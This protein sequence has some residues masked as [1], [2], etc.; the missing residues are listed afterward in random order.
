M[1][2][3]IAS[4][5][6]Y[7]RQLHVWKEEKEGY[8]RFYVTPLCELINSSIHCI[9]NKY[10]DDERYIYRFSVRLWDKQV[11]LNMD[12][13]ITKRIHAHNGW[14][15]NQNQPSTLNF[16]LFIKD[17]WLCQRLVKDSIKD[18]GEFLANFKLELEFTIISGQ[19]ES[20]NLN[21]T[22]SMLR[23][24]NFF[25]YL[26]NEV[27]AYGNIYL[28]STDC[29]KLAKNIYQQVA[30]DDVMTSGYIPSEQ[31]NHIIQ[32]LLGIIS[33]Q[34]VE[35]TRLSELE[36]NSVFWDDIFTRP[37]I[38]TEY[39]NEV[40]TYNQSCNCFNFH[41]N[42]EREFYDKIS[43]QYAN[44]IS[45]S[46]GDGDTFGIGSFPLGTTKSND[47]IDETAKHFIKPKIE[48]LDY[49]VKLSECKRLWEGGEAITRWIDKWRE[50]GC[51]KH[52][53]YF[54]SY[55]TEKCE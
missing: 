41:S 53:A 12:K 54:T 46:S 28:T 13:W 25:T 3:V 16:E 40:F 23:K 20:H 43:Y 26:S 8:N 47:R 35:S 22:G 50:M 38:Q 48:W 31:E 39:L 29:N 37:D 44:K 55:R 2:H 32:E 1:E 7:G 45:K 21:I 18:P 27:N 5:E 52:C 24:T 49:H 11:R 30:V 9:Q 14:R 17:K 34:Q 15:S 51:G 10:A 36:W 19:T 6:H 33:E 4:V 42:K